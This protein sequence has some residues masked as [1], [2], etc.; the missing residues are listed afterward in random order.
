[1]ES[2]TVT[3]V[4]NKILVFEEELKDLLPAAVL[5]AR[6]AYLDGYSPLPNKILKCRTYPLYKLIREDLGTK[7]LSGA[8]A[9]SPG[10][11]IEIVYEAISQGKIAGP[12]LQCVSGWTGA[13][14]PF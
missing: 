9:R 8:E 4:F 14:G 2:N 13:P 6:D 7:L 1:V 10:Q 5:D 11:D 3:S 12:L